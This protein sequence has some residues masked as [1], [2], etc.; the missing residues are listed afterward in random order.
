MSL[1]TQ[2]LMFVFLPHAPKLFGRI[3]TRALCFSFHSCNEMLHQRFESLGWVV[4]QSQ[5][6]TCFHSSDIISTN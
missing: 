4:F 1:S 6:Y 2:I 5:G 3:K